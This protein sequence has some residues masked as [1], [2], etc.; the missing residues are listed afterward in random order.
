[1]GKLVNAEFRRRRDR[2]AELL[3]GDA[4]EWLA[5]VMAAQEPMAAALTRVTLCAAGRGYSREVAAEALRLFPAALASLR[6]LAEP[7]RVRGYDL[8]P[9][10]NVMV[11]FPLI[12][13]DRRL[14]DDPDSFRPGRDD[15]AM[16]FGGGDRRCLGRHIAWTELDTIV[17]IALERGVRPLGPQ[18]EKMVLRGT[19]LVPRRSGLVRA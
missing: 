3:E 12:H 9:G 13:R 18:P 6:E 4:D 5:L 1:M 17:P 19:I 10:T 7:L 8:A 14:F 15:G 16:P 2:V 11:P